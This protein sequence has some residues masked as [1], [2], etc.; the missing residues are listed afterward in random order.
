MTFAAPRFTSETPTSARR[1]STQIACFPST[2]AVFA[3]GASSGRVA[4]T[5]Y[6]IR[7]SEDV[8]TLV[9]APEHWATSGIPMLKET[10]EFVLHLVS[11]SKGFADGPQGDQEKDGWKYIRSKLVEPNG[12][13]IWEGLEQIGNR[14]RSSGP[15]TAA[16]PR[17][18]NSRG[19]RQSERER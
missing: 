8:S 13:I 11:Q 9:P 6:L 17:A 12:D 18:D 2:T 10:A 4:D 7:R 19:P 15:D 16:I 3:A 5:I 14:G 1:S